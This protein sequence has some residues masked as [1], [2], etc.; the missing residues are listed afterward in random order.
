VIIDIST[1][2]IRGAFGSIDEELSCTQCHDML[3]THL[4]DVVTRWACVNVCTNTLFAPNRFSIKY[5]PLRF[6]PYLRFV[7]ARSDLMNEDRISFI[8]FHCHSVET[9]R[10]ATSPSSLHPYP[11][12]HPL[13]S[14]PSIPVA[15]SLLHA[16]EDARLSESDASVLKMAWNMEFRILTPSSQQIHA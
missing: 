8:S 1:A 11:Y 6:W 2:S 3:K 12:P 4:K 5:F 9:N 16:F 14:L 10:R 15:V 7:S 13:S